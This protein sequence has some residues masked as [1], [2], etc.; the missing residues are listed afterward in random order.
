M[1]SSTSS[2]MEI[3]KLNGKLHALDLDN[4]KLR[5]AMLS[6]QSLLDQC[7]NLLKQQTT[8]LDILR[9]K[10]EKVQSEMKTVIDRAKKMET[11]LIKS[12]KGLLTK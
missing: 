8:A 7:M 10:Y 5:E 1:A 3:E 2:K 11:E 6:R 9:L 12:S 4:R